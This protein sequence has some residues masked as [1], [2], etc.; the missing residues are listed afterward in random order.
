M[1][2]ARQRAGDRARGKTA[3]ADPPAMR[4]SLGEQIAADFAAGRVVVVD[5]WVVAVTEAMACAVV[6]AA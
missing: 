5:G 6:Y 3:E 4:T 2:A 1:I